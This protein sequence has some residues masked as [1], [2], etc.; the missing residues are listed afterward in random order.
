V[1]LT[2]LNGGAREVFVAALGSVFE[3]SPWVA[4][5]A[6]ERKPFRS[7]DELHESMIDAVTAAEPDRQLTLL[8]AHP[9][10]GTRARMSDASTGEQSAAGLDRLTPAEFARLQQLN[11]AYR[12][13]FD[14]PFLLAVRGVTKQ[15]VFAAIEARLSSSLE[16][17]RAEALRQV[18]R[19]ARFRLADIVS[20]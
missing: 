14:F 17:E 16:E 8:R 6:W 19:I 4:E 18:S 15:D 20:E 7:I 5:R 3:R 1:T 11:R 10:L 9:D 13:K 2:D 12:Q